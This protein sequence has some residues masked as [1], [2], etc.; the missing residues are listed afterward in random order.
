MGL[1]AVDGDEVDGAVGGLAEGFGGGLIDGCVRSYLPVA[2][3]DV[4]MAAFVEDAH[5]VAEELE[6]AATGI[7]GGEGVNIHL[8]EFLAPVG[9]ELVE[10]AAFVPCRPIGLSHLAEGCLKVV[11]HQG[12]VVVV[13]HV[14]GLCFGHRV[15]GVVGVG[16][17]VVHIVARKVAA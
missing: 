1:F 13:G 9:Q 5:V 4:G 2:R 12:H 15:L 6:G 10:P 16:A 3:G 11:G 8:A 7:V 14:G 17:A